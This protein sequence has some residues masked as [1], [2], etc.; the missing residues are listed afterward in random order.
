MTNWQKKERKSTEFFNFE[1]PGDELI[2][3]VQDFREIP[4]KFGNAKVADLT[5][6]DNAPLSVIITAGMDL[7]E[8]ERGK[9]VKVVF[10]SWD[11]NPKTGNVFKRF[12]TYVEPDIAEE[13]IPI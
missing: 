6:L 8:S 4:T 2:G 7:G 5:G 9:L 3:T 12:D 13:D 10:L 11:K 1:A